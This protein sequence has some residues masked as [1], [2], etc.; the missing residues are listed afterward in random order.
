VGKDHSASVK[1]NRICRL[2]ETQI[3]DNGLCVW[4]R[5]EN[6]ARG[7]AIS[8]FNN[9]QLAELSRKLKSQKNLATGPTSSYYPATLDGAISK[10]P[11]AIFLMF[12]P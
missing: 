3:S 9:I 12:Q 1:K 10:K 5:F 7:Y 2:I 4:H 8:Y 11:A 6:A